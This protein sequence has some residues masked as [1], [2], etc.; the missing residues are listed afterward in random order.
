V[1]SSTKA[2]PPADVLGIFG[3]AGDL[4]KK[5]TFDSL[6][7]LEARGLLGIPI[8]GVAAD[9]W[10]LDQLREDAHASIVNIAL[11]HGLTPADRHQ[12]ATAGSVVARVISW[13]HVFEPQWPDR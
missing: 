8:V 4:A 12:P 6:Y 13:V 7:R 2:R 5:M 1:L 9:D 10:S 3:I 11:V